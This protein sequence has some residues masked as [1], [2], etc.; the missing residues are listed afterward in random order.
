M[1]DTSVGHKVGILDAAHR[2]LTAAA[3]C[4]VAVVAYNNL[5]VSAALP[6]IGD[7]FGSLR[8]LPWVVTVELLASAVAT[9]AAGPVID[10]LGTRRVARAAMVGFGVSCLICGFAPSLAALIAGR[11]LQG[12]MAGTIFAAVLV[13]VGLGY[14]AELR[15]R[16]Y[17]ANSAVWGVM[18]VAGPAL[19]AIVI[20][21]GE[22]PWVFHVNL[23][24][25]A[26][27][28]AAGWSIFPER[29]DG[30]PSLRIDGRGLVIVIAFTITVLVG[31]SEPTVR[32]LAPLA[33]GALIAVV[34]LRHATNSLDPILRRE[35][36]FARRYRYIHLTAVFSVLGGI[37]S[38]TFLPVWMKAAQGA[39]SAGAAFSVV[40]LTVGW[41]T[42]AFVSS[43]I[44]EVRRIEAAITFGAGVLMVGASI[45]AAGV[46]GDL[47]VGVV[48]AGFVIVGIGV[49]SVSTGSLALMQSRATPNEMGRSNSAFQFLRTLGFAFGAA[50]GGLAMF[51]TAASR[52]GSADAVRDLLSDEAVAAS[53]DLVAAVDDGFGLSAVIGL[54]CAVVCVVASRAV[55][56]GRGLRHQEASA[57]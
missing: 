21:F 52:F 31:L 43:R 54:A 51:G 28:M 44:A 11:A 3:M 34:Y 53:A 10:A 4:L 18:G 6:S 2:R 46:L 47:A 23:P 48:F 37:T 41:T 39:S 57:R 50:L 40:W 9:L 32:S 26:F 8:W 27:A 56:A 55:A 25:V 20:G 17:A 15:P 7:D 33:I 29:Q 12:L 49:G 5:S 16:A 45:V 24:F 19:A 13:T 38:N 35:H 22:W 30:A 36:L 1:T 42:G 14:P